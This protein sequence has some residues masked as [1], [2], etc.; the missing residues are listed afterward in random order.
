MWG[1]GGRACGTRLCWVLGEEFMCNFVLGAKMQE[2]GGRGVEHYCI[3][4][5]IILIR[6]LMYIEDECQM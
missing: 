3:K 6:V 4:I 1:G 2:G 5:L